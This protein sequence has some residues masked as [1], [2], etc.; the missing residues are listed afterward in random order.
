MAGISSQ[1]HQEGYYSHAI[2]HENSDRPCCH[3]TNCQAPKHS[4][5]WTSIMGKAVQNSNTGTTAAYTPFITPCISLKQSLKMAFGEC[6]PGDR[7]ILT[8]FSNSPA[9]GCGPHTVYFPDTSRR[10]YYH[11]PP[12]S[13][14]YG[15]PSSRNCVIDAEQDR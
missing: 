15:L 5:T 6:W 1:L 12:S 2:M 11:R 10:A 14:P 13:G 4:L 7:T 8:K 3:V 9:S